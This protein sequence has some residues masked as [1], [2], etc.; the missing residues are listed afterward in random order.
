MILQTKNARKEINH[1]IKIREA[2]LNF[3]KTILGS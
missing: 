2:I 3:P 1:I